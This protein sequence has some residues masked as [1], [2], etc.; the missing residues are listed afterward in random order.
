LGIELTAN[1]LDM[2]KSFLAIVGADEKEFMLYTNVACGSSKFF[3]AAMNNDWRESHQNRV[4]LVEIDASDFEHYL[5]WLSTNDHS[6]L[7][8]TTFHQ[9]AKLYIL[10]DFLDDSA[11]RGDML[12]PFT[13]KA[14]TQNAYPDLEIIVFIWE[15]T[16]ERSP[17]RRIAVEAWIT[18][19]IERLASKFASA[20]GEA[21]KAIIVDC[22]RRISETKPRTK[23]SITG[24]ARRQALESRRDEVLK[25][26]VA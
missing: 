21:P 8:D 10:G 7:D 13:S 14:V 12:I 5:Q 1:R 22:L 20:D 2:S 4:T 9:L 24:A 15:R 6:F 19:S 3:H 25:D 18:S 17:L 11:F 16:P 26:L 23:E